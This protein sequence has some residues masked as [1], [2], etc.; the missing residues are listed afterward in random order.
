[1]QLNQQDHGGHYGQDNGS[2]RG[3]HLSVPTPGRP[4]AMFYDPNGPWYYADGAVYNDATGVTT[5]KLFKRA[6]EG[7]NLVEVG[8]LT[9]D[10]VQPEGRALRASWSLNGGF[11]PR[12]PG[13]AGN[14]RFAWLML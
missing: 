14:G 5:L 13:A 10:P 6:G 7:G 1:M 3:F 12:P 8:T 11:S 2:G 9:I 4:I